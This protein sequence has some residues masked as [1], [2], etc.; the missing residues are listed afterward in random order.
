MLEDLGIMQME[1]LVGP[2]EQEWLLPLP[3]KITMGAGR[4]LAPF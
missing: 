4:M 1:L 2:E 3:G